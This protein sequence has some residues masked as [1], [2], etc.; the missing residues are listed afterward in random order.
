MH[1]V[2]S[3]LR[4]L[5]RTAERKRTCNRCEEEFE[6]ALRIVPLARK[7]GFSGLLGLKSLERQSADRIYGRKRKRSSVR[8]V[9]HVR[10][11]PTSHPPGTLY[12][13]ACGPVD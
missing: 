11:Q 6:Y 10:K 7:A 13:I 12:S 5:Y 2:V 4:E 9:Y 3:I 8:M 1:L